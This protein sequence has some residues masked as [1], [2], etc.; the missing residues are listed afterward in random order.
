MT[1]IIQII[2]NA[3]IICIVYWIN[4]II[5][6][7]CIA[8]SL[9]L[10]PPIHTIRTVIQFII[11]IM[12]GI[13]NVMARLTNKFVFV[14]FLF[15]SS[16]LFSSCFSVLN[17]RI[18]G[19]PVKISR[20]TRFN[21]STRSCTILNFGITTKNNT[22]TTNTINPTASAIIQDISTFV[23]NTFVI[24]PIAIIGAYNTIRRIITVK[25]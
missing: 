3:I 24:P 5:S 9:T 6:P 8:P 18:T 13:I 25:S 15:A 7:T 1:E 10:Y 12:V 21:R 19:S 11:S 4:A 14:R 22:A 2:R 23:W 20:L 17:A 16:N